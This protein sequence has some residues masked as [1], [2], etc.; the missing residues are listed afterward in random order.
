M[1]NYKKYDYLLN[2]KKSKL[3]I[4][5][6]KD[7][8]EGKRKRIFVI[9]DCD[10]GNTGTMS[11]HDF[12]RRPNISCGCERNRLSGE[13]NF[14]DGRKKMPE[15]QV[16]RLMIDRCI[17]LKNKHYKDYGGRGISVCE[18][19][20]NDFANFISDMGRKPDPKLTIE[21]I[22]NNGNYEP[23]NCK[24]ATMK[25]QNN[26]KRNNIKNKETLKKTLR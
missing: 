9:C 22:N 14:I 12:K 24:W 15:Y 19:W 17:N 8:Y 26:N 1:E 10:C 21:R 3:T 6:F 7:G 11:L 25:E 18:R 23:E 5:D 20:N 4:V 16:W 13:R 2:T